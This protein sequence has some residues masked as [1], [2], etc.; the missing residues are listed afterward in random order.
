MIR[1]ES[2]AQMNKHFTA[3]R[4]AIFAFLLTTLLRTSVSLAAP[5]KE[6]W[7]HD[8]HVKGD[9]ELAGGARAADIL[10]SR[11]DFTVVQIAAQNLVDDVERVT[12]KK[13][14]LRTDVSHISG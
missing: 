12:G 4:L 7:I 1:R 10:V 14:A 11:D 6:S 5:I 9:F 3:T 13:P 2:L 8:R